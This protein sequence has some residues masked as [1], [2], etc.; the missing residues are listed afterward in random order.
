MNQVVIE[1]FKLNKLENNCFSAII[2]EQNNNLVFD[3]ISNMSFI[4]S[5]VVFSDKNIYDNLVGDLFIHS[6][7]NDDII[8][9]ILARQKLM[10]N[11][12]NNNILLIF[13]TQ[14]NI[15]EYDSFHDIIENGYLFNIYSLIVTNSINNLEIFDYIFLNFKNKEL[16]EKFKDCFNSY[17]QYCQLIKSINNKFVTIDVKN[18]KIF[19]Y[20]KNSNE[21]KIS[22]E[23][24][25][26]FSDM[27]IKKNI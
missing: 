17:N 9:N 23:K 1:E 3:L 14:Q 15:F 26:K 18:K 24:Q 16:Y 11:K 21:N 6:L 10:I 8:S 20:E 25:K 2:F 7:Y 12:N 27:N 13:D 4:S 5:A 22:F 19:Y